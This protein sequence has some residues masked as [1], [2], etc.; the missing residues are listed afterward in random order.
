VIETMSK[1][2]MGGKVSVIDTGG[3][4]RGSDCDLLCC[5]PLILFLQTE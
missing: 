4:I 2:G 3:Y 5:H 1:S